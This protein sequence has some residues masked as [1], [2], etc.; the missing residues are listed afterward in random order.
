MIEV[1]GLTKDY[2]TVLALRGLSFR[3]GVGE[4]VGF[5]G[6][7]G[8][9][10]STTL[11][12]LAGYLGQ[13]AGKVRIGGHDLETASLAVRRLIGYMPETSPLYPELRVREYLTFRAALKQVPRRERCRAIARA[14][15]LAA[16]EAE[17]DTLTGHLSRGFRQRV[18]L[19]DA[20]LASPPLLI[21]DEPTAGLDPNQIREVRRVIREL[22]REHTIL[23]STHIL[24]EVETTCDRA[25]VVSRGRLVGEGPIEELREQRRGRRVR[26]VLR[27]TAG[28]A[29]ELL[30]AR[31]GVRVLERSVLEPGVVR[32]ELRI[33]RSSEGV[34]AEA[35]LAC[36]VA[37][38]IGVRE[39]SPIRA[40]LE[41]VF[42]TLTQAPNGVQRE[43]SLP[44]DDS[45][46]ATAD[47]SG[48]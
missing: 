8:A 20:L 6:P 44:A 14:M 23:L 13:T 19:A 34:E 21:L 3:V 15:E 28:A 5:V 1:E 47:G 37:A 32:L 45:A 35:L 24:S 31:E 11:R 2:G 25:L 30:G 16:V 7:N 17:A 33:E 36:L 48:S 9:G 42:A 40:S 10:K 12:I 43:P 29:A 4:V 38:G 46:A 18:G 41:D 26:L 22:G 39:L 27:D